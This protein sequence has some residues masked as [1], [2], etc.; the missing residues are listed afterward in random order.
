[1]GGGKS[2]NFGNTKG[3]ALDALSSLLAWASLI[4]GLDTFTNLASIPVDLARGDFVSAGLSAFGAVPFIGEV[5]DTAKLA[6][7]ASDTFK[8]GAKSIINKQKRGTPRS[9]KAQNKQTTSIAKKLNLSPKQQREL[10]DLIHGQN[11]GY[12]EIFEFAKS[13]FDK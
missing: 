9:N 13:W 12:Q 7:N 8:A 2:G 6:D 3:S 5:A 11:W 4:P 10:H 1:M